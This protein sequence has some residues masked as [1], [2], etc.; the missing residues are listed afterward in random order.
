MLLCS[1]SSSSV[2]SG[3]MQ[4]A[5]L[6][7]AHCV[8]DGRVRA[9][10]PA[11]VS[12]EICGRDIR[13]TQHHTGRT[14]WRNDNVIAR[15]GRG[16]RDGWRVP[17]LYGRTVAVHHSQS[18]TTWTSD[19][20]AAAAIEQ[21]LHMR[22]SAC[23]NSVGWNGCSY[24]FRMRRMRCRGGLQARGEDMA[25]HR[26]ACAVCVCVAGREVS[27]RQPFGERTNGSL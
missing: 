27:V 24:V 12:I 5:L 19:A 3:N 15:S 22:R 4:S 25:G 26:T 18:R 9:F 23:F 20:A 17:S 13:N 7:S 11:L 2:S 10:V 14:Q 6:T 1:R 16:G 8:C 21:L